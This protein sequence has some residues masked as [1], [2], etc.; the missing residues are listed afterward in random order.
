MDLRLTKYESEFQL[1][2]LFD[3][4]YIIESGPDM[5]RWLYYDTIIVQAIRHDEYVLIAKHNIK[6]HTQE[7]YVC[8][9]FDIVLKKLGYVI[10]CI[11]TD[12]EMNGGKELV[13]KLQILLDDL[14]LIKNK[15]LTIKL[16]EY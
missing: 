13:S 15:I 4:D 7:Y 9:S 2:E 16:E 12:Y 6:A 14:N 10:A 5:V 1:L 3:S 8:E 11:H